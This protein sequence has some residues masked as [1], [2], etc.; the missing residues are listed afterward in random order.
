MTIDFPFR[1]VLLVMNC[2]PANSR[3]WV[4]QSSSSLT[5]F[6]RIESYVLYDFDFRETEKKKKKKRKKRSGG[7][8]ENVVQ[9]CYDVEEE[10][11]WNSAGLFE[12]V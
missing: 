12:C 2:V 6:L 5:K 8:G 9:N 7:F 10:E 1:S 11:E 4:S 3:Y